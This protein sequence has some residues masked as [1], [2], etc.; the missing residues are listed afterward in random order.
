MEENVFYVGLML[1]L[2]SFVT[3]EIMGFFP[4]PTKVLVNLNPLVIFGKAL[5]VALVFI[6]Y[7]YAERVRGAVA[8]LTVFV[9]ILFAVS[10][11]YTLLR[12]VA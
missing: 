8:L 3:Q 2:M 10:L 4:V 12:F 9:Y 6:L 7:P 11:S 5:V 1:L